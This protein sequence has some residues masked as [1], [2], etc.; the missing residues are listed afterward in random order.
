MCRTVFG[1]GTVGH[2][3][4]PTSLNSNNAV[5]DYAQSNF[6]TY[7][8]WL[9]VSEE[10][11]YKSNGLP[12]TIDPIPWTSGYPYTGSSYSG[13]CINIYNGKWRNNLACSTSSGYAICEKSDPLGESIWGI[14]I[15]SRNTK[16]N[17]YKNLKRIDFSTVSQ[18]VI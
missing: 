11:K 7:W 6:G 1:S 5:Y 2:I 9:G 16:L 4:E 10:L 14:L 3:F 15:L 8:F 18:L 13:N 17:Y 12:V